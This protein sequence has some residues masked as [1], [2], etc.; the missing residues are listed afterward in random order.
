MSVGTVDESVGP[1]RAVD[2]AVAC[3]LGIGEV[4]S[5]RQLGELLGVSED[6][7]TEP[8]SMTYLAITS[9]A[10]EAWWKPIRFHFMVTTTTTEGRGRDECWSESVEE[11]P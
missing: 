9:E 5:D 7:V 10:T 4:V 2:L 6:G 3:V 8:R 11:W 1:E